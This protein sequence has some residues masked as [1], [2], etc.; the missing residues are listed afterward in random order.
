MAASAS[1]CRVQSRSR[2]PGDNDT[3]NFSVESCSVIHVQCGTA[4][5]STDRQ[6]V[7]PAVTVAP[8]FCAQPEDG[9]TVLS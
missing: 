3:S 6:S 2:T 8:V 4:S 9:V 1:D 5:A 7:T